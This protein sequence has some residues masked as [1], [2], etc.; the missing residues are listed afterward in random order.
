MRKLKCNPNRKT[1]GYLSTRKESNI[2]FKSDKLQSFYSEI[3]VEDQ[4][5]STFHNEDSLYFNSYLQGR[6]KDILFKRVNQLAKRNLTATQ[7]NVYELCNT[8][9]YT[10]KEIGAVLGIGQS[11][12]YK[13]INGNSDYSQPTTKQY[14]GYVQKLRKATSKDWVCSLLIKKLGE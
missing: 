10:Q 9:K 13:I 14:G 1:L 6:I 5:L 12:V 7:F 3:P 11:S 8:G 4:K 2:S